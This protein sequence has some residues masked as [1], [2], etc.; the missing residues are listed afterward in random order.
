MFFG[1]KHTPTLAHLL[2]FKL[3]HRVLHAIIVSAI[4]AIFKLAGKVAD[5]V[6]GKTYKT[7]RNKAK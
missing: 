3:T 6:A 1:S 2:K 7:E 5:A 4:L